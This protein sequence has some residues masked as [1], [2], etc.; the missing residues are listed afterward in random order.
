L[1]QALSLALSC[2]ATGDAERLQ[3]HLDKVDRRAEH[4]GREVPPKQ[5]WESLTASELRVVGLVTEGL[6]NRAVAERLFLSPHTV[7]SHLRHVFA[8]LGV[9]TRVELTRIAATHAFAPDSPSTG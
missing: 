7:N 5:G 2:G 3:R 8:K 1:R 9:S 6:S 4:P